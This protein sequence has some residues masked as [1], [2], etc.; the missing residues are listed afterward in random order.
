MDK[1][2]KLLN[3]TKS[4]NFTGTKILVKLYRAT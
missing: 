3:V 4:Y 2:T 1:I